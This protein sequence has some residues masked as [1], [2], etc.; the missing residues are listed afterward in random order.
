M[1]VTA[2]EPAQHV[3][4]AGALIIEV[5]DQPAGYLVVRLVGELDRASVPAL[6]RELQLALATDAEAVVVD[7]EGLEFIDS[8]GVQCLIRLVRGPDGRRLPLIGAGGQPRRTFRLLGLDPLFPL[9]NL[10]LDGFQYRVRL[11]HRDP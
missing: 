8:S 1:P 11:S 9:A 10:A 4:A 5:Y 7:L 2:S 3:V 6:E